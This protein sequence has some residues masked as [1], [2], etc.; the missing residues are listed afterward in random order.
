VG[1]AGA[2]L[3]YPLVRIG[4][5]WNRR[6]GDGLVALSDDELGIVESMA[7]AMY[8][9]GGPLGDSVRVYHV[10]FF[11]DG[12][13]AA[14]NPDLQRIMKAALHALDDMTILDDSDLTPF[15]DR[16]LDER[17]AVLQ[18]WELSS[19]FEK[20]SLLRL[21]KWYITMGLMEAPGVQERLGLDFVCS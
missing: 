6:P 9:P 21:Y 3:G 8:P 1:G 14:M 13:V 5:W 12:Q 4:M 11:I 17:I 10:G 15:T 16:S 19:S 7:E 20:R 18:A 2:V